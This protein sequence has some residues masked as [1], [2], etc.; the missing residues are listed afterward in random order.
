VRGR[1]RKGGRRRPSFVVFLSFFEGRKTKK[2][3]D[4][5]VQG[6][7]YSHRRRMKGS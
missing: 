1:G 4:D 7:Y 2:A 6:T 5:D 3:V